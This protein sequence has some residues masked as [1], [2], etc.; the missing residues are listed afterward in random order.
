MHFTTLDNI[1]KASEEEICAVDEIGDVIAKSIVGF[2]RQEQNLDIIENLRKYGVNFVCNET[3]KDGVFNGKVFVLTGTLPTLTRSEASKII[4]DNGGKVS[5]S[6]SK[7]TDF[8][9]AGEEAGSKLD[10]ANQLG[11]TVIAEEEFRNML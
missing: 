7:K 9:L 10:K 5:S 8:V 2:F 11:I 6:V 1:I 4:A 3:K